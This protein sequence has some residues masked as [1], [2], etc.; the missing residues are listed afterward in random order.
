MWDK[1]VA[2]F[3]AV[4]RMFFQVDGEGLQH[5]DVSNPLTDITKVVFA[6]GIGIIIAAI[7]IYYHKTVVGSVVRA[8]AKANAFSEETAVSVSSLPVKASF[9]ER[10][11]RRDTTLSRRV[12]TVETK[13]GDDRYYIPESEREELLKR[14]SKDG[15][16]LKILIITVA[17]T[18]A[19]I[20]AFLSFRNEILLGIDFLVGFFTIE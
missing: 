16:D 19:A 12:K 20:A 15:S 14:Y 6:L 7:V 17:V 18:I 3:N 5:I 9:F 10:K 13:E 4:D 1:I 11:V 8:L 2:F